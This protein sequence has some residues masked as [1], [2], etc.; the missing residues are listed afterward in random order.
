M[1]INEEYLNGLVES[2]DGYFAAAED[3]NDN[4]A[5]TAK[6]VSGIGELLKALLY[7]HDEGT[8]SDIKK[9]FDFCLTLEPDLECVVE[10]FSLLTEDTTGV[11]REIIVDSANEIWDCI[12]DL[13][14]EE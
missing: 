6:F 8:Q 1:E 12:V 9:T 2:A 10:E 13:L 3:K 4:E 5:M 7:L 14:S 11:E